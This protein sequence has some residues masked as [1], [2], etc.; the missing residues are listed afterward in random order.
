MG[1]LPWRVSL[2][3]RDIPGMWDPDND[4]RNWADAKPWPV[5]ETKPQKQTAP[6]ARNALEALEVVKQH[7]NI[8]WITPYAVPHVWVYDPRFDKFVL[9]PATAHGTVMLKWEEQ[10]GLN[11]GYGNGDVY[12]DDASY[13][14]LKMPRGRLYVWED[15]TYELSYYIGID[16]FSD[17]DAEERVYKL[18]SILENAGMEGKVQRGFGFGEAINSFQSGW[19][20]IKRKNKVAKRTA[21]SQVGEVKQKN[22]QVISRPG[23]HRYHK[24]KA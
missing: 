16:P 18:N 15:G 8:A 9:G 23:W 10:N 17:E 1:R 22:S 7:P 14:G 20:P 12:F 2:H 11:T 6:V 21:F 19:P 13:D 5:P 4:P 24:V 3:G